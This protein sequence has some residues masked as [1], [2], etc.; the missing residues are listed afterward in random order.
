ML[1]D[2]GV[3]GQD[4]LQLR[5]TGVELALLVFRLVILAILAQVAK[6][7][8]LLDLVGH[9]FLPDGL[10]VVEFFLEFFQARRAQLILFRHGAKHPFKQ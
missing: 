3:V 4:I 1:F 5:D 10:E 8:G 7:T 6:G 9:F 2:D